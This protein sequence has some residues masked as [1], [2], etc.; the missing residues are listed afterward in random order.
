MPWAQGTSGLNPDAPANLLGKLKA[1][2]RENQ[3]FRKSGAVLG[4]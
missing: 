1:P 2:G 4:C 3:D